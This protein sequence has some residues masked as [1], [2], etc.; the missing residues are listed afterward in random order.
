VT[1]VVRLTLLSHAMT[2]AMAGGRFPTDEPL[3]SIGRRQVEA[4]ATQFVPAGRQ[5]CGPERRV[6]ETAKLL[7]LQA[8]T[9]PLLADLDCGRWRGEALSDVSPDELEAWLSEPGAAPH[10]GESITDLMSRVAQWLE[11]LSANPLRVMAVTHPAVIRAAI[12]VALDIA[13]TSFWRIDVAPAG[14][15]VMHCRGGRWTL[16]L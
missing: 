6:R 10:G 7:G 8:D 1:E 5:L 9:E 12:V 4:V 14:R 3:N 16:R 11:S 15:I 13:P 2:D